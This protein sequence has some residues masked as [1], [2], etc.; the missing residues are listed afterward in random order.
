MRIANCSQC[1]YC[2]KKTYR[3]ISQV[4]ET[5]YECDKHDFTIAEYNDS[6][7]KYS[8]DDNTADKKMKKIGFRRI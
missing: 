3:D 2:N 5:Y 8:C 4:T 7:T 6:I 1:D